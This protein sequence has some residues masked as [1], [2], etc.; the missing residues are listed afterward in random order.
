VTTLT[1]HPLPPEGEGYVEVVDPV[2]PYDS[3][4]LP[5]PPPPATPGRL[6]RLVRGRADDP[7]W[8]RPAMLGL[9]LATALL[10]IWG[11]GASGWANGFYS[12]A[13]QA[14]TKSW[15]AFFFGSSDAANFI[16]V[17]KPPASLWVMEISARIFGLNAW[18]VL[19]PQA[20]EGVAAVGLLYATVRRWFSPAAALI[21]GAVMA[22]TP[23]AVLMFRFNNPDALL[24]LLLVGAA[25]AVTRAIE[26]GRM[27][28]LVLA[29]ALIGTGFITKML[30]AF[31]V[32]PAFA[33][34]FL[35]V[36]P[37]SVWSRIR[38]L[39]AAGVALIVS[40][41]W[42]VAIV[43]LV[44]A[45]DRPYIGGS[46]DNSV[47]GLALG[48][49]GLGRITGNETG[50]VVG[51]GGGA[52]GG[53]GL[54]GQTGWGRLFGSD[55]GGQVAW[56]LP[57]A[58]GLMAYVLWLTRRTTR[59]N[60]T[61]AA[62]ML[63]GG[64]LL[65]TAGTFSF[66]KG[67]IHPYYT[68]ALA[69]AIGALVGIG[70]ATLWR[71]RAW[72]S[73]R[74][75]AAAI[76]VLSAWWSYELLNRTPTWHPALREAVLIGGLITAVGLVVG[77]MVPRLAGVA[78]GASLVVVLAGPAAYAVSTAS[79][80]HT[81]AI[82][83]AGPSGQGG[84]FGGPGGGRGGFGQ[85][86]GGQGRGQAQGQTGQGGPPGG[87]TGGGQG[88]GGAQGQTQGQTGQ[89][90]GAPGGTRGGGFGGL[91]DAGT[92]SAA[93]VTLLKDGA[94]G[95]RWT[96]AAVG[97]NT[98]AGI[99][100]GSGEPIM[101]IGGFNG[102][103]PAPTLAQFEA[104]VSAHKIHYFIASGGGFGNQLGGS[105]VSAQ[106]TTWVEANF[107]AQTVGGTT[108]YDLSGGAASTTSGT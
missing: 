105:N 16:T 99:Q 72:L 6:T 2:A 13:V 17:D 71:M 104:W 20:L 74:I 64:W 97:S 11:L 100:L 30:Q 34:V 40:S 53:G 10:Y 22:L 54:W 60:R 45:A 48:Y 98:A 38:A 36:A 47:L 70:G 41:G 8:A 84:G 55:M 102:S 57:A 94:S 91:L 33:L 88:Q 69:P 76:L 92:P 81:G 68:V 73:A 44:P 9:L 29:S 23:V 80:P 1:T 46:Q 62:V 42:W 5:T 78:A 49:N 12:A 31:L 86:P 66:M 67:I 7:T 83:S 101:A 37:T 75:V 65:V 87:F 39:L 27:A 96:A 90:P 59:L 89:A 107:T 51:G 93:L 58:L 82:P 56:L 108:V 63:W 85:R 43:A 106:I 95:Y 77:P 19:V 103:D 4:E 32:V 15:E 26:H 79:T 35:V 14:G 24:V 52:T 25:Y 21:A 3:G 61:R 28:W 18:S 50:S